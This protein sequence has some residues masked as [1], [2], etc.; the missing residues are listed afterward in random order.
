MCIQYPGFLLTIIKL[1]CRNKKRR[2]GREKRER[3]S[4]MRSGWLKGWRYTIMAWHMYCKPDLSLFSLTRTH[5]FVLF[6]VAIGGGEAA[7][8]THQR[9]SKSKTISA[10]GG[11]EWVRIPR[12]TRKG[13]FSLRPLRRPRSSDCTALHVWGKERR[14]REEGVWALHALGTELS[15]CAA[16]GLVAV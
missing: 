6:V 3:W 1:E 10:V 13:R 4:R 14:G 2:R 8:S 12:R 5:N 9:G 11:S 7:L 15:L 16:G